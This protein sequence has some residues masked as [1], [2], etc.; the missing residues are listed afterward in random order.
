MRVWYHDVKACIFLKTIYFPNV[1]HCKKL[2]NYIFGVPT[3]GVYSINN[4]HIYGVIMHKIEFWMFN[5]SKII[6][7]I[8]EHMLI[9]PYYKLQKKST[10][11]QL[12]THFLLKHDNVINLF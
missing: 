9:Q 5:Q 6:S 10:Y 12:L 2:S 4:K 7:C 8:Y 11:I 3:I 1:N